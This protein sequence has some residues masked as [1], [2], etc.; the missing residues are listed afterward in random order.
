MTPRCEAFL[1]FNQLAVNSFNQQGERF[2]FQCV[3]VTVAAGRAEPSTNRAAY[4][5]PCRYFKATLIILP[6]LSRY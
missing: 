1:H 5:P 6:L 4:Y 2:L 3:R